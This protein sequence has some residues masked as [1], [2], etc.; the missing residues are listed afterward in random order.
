M[1]FSASDGGSGFMT[2]HTNSGGTNDFLKTWMMAPDPAADAHHA[3]F[4]IEVV[5]DR[6]AFSI[7]SWDF[8][9]ART[10]PVPQV[11]IPL[12]P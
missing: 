6:P 8:F 4:I 9:V 7:N 12:G 1:D 11:D 2:S 10:S 5:K 3:A